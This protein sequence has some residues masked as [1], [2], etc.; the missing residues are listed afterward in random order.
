MACR[1][2]GDH[3]DGSKDDLKRSRDPL[4]SHWSNGPLE[5]PPH[6]TTTTTRH[7]HT[8]TR[9]ASGDERGASGDERGASGDER[10]SHYH[11]DDNNNNDDDG[12][13]NGLGDGLGD[14]P[15]RSVLIRIDPY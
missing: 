3:H 15:Y 14:G 8:H 1:A 9:G 5:P 12:L 6:P 10:S 13:G 2:L 4:L 7:T 11:N